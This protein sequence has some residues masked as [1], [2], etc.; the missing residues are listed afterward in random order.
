MLRKV[1]R[2]AHKRKYDCARPQYSHIFLSTL[3]FTAKLLRA[4]E[5]LSAGVY[6]AHSAFTAETTHSKCCSAWAARIIGGEEEEGNHGILS[7][8]HMAA[9]EAIKSFHV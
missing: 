2:A 8:L 9:A 5:K 1:E 4:Y 3:T 6:I 7:L